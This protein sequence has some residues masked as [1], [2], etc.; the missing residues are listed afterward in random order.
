M[1]SAETKPVRTCSRCGQADDHPRHVIGVPEGQPKANFHMDCHA[2]LGCPICLEQIRDADGAQ[3]A[4]LQGHLIA[5][6]ALDDARIAE[7]LGAPT[8]VE[9]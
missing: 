7:L 3:G 9:G 1:T 2:L 8:T 5:K 4:E 6:P